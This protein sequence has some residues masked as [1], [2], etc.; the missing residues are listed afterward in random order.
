MN[1]QLVQFRRPSNPSRDSIA[2]VATL[3]QEVADLR[4]EGERFKRE[5]L[6]FRL[7]V[8]FGRVAIAMP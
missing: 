3:R 7:Q 1:G 5:N 8:G 2:S 4:A 6:E